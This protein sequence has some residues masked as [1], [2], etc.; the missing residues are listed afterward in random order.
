MFFA[1]LL[2]SPGSLQGREYPLRLSLPIPPSLSKATIW[3]TGNIA[4]LCCSTILLFLLHTIHASTQHLLSHLSGSILIIL[5]ITQSNDNTLSSGSNPTTIYPPFNDILFTFLYYY[6]FLSAH[7][8][9][10]KLRVR[11]LLH[12]SFIASAA[13]AA[14]FDYRSAPS[15]PPFLRRLPRRP[16][17]RRA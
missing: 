7:V 6:Y 9:M 15:P 2:N 11:L 16:S 1:N 17:S 5:H 8:G 12:A 10:T 4:V 14:P 3:L 13:A